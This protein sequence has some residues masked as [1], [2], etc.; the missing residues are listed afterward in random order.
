M[1]NANIKDLLRRKRVYQW[2]IA[3]KLNVSEITFCRWLRQDL[4]EEKQRQ[5]LK[6]INEIVADR[7]KM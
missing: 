5:I 4:P 3:A 2:E 1:P 7:A 6:A